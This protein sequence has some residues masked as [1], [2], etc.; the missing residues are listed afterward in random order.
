MNLKLRFLFGFLLQFLVLFLSYSLVFSGD[1]ILLIGDSITN[2]EV[3]STDGLGFRNDLYDLI[4]SS[5]YN[6]SF[7]GDVGQNPYKGHFRDGGRIEEF[8]PIGYGTGELDA[9]GVIDSLQPTI[10]MVFL[11]TNNVDGA[12]VS[13]FSVDNGLT[14]EDNASG[15]L[16]QFLNYLANW[17]NGNYGN[18]I[19]SILVVKIIPKLNHIENVDK[20]NAEISKFVNMAN[21]G[22]FHNIRP[23]L[24][25]II[26]CNSDFDINQMMSAGG[27][28]P[29]DLGYNFIAHKY[30]NVLRRLPS[31][32]EIASGNNQS[33]FSGTP[34]PDSIVVR[35]LDFAG[36]AASFTPIL[37]QTP[38]GQGLVE[39]DSI[40][41]TDQNGYARVKWTQLNTGV[42]NLNIEIYHFPDSK[43]VCNSYVNKQN[44]HPPVPPRWVFE[45]WA[46]QGDPEENNEYSLM[47]MVNKYLEN[48]IPLGAVIID[49]PWET[50]YNSFE[51]DQTYDQGSPDEPGYPD[52]KNMIDELHS[53]GIKVICWITNFI[54]INASDGDIA[55]RNTKSPNYDYAFNHGYFIN[56]GEVFNWWKGQGSAIDFFNPEA[57]DWYAGQLDK[58]LDLG[59]DGW[60]IDAGDVYVPDDFS[61]AAGTATRRMYSDEYYSFFYHYTIQKLGEENAVTIA[62]PYVKD[63]GPG[64]KPYIFAPISVSPV[65]WVG[66]Q[67]DNWGEKGLLEAL[68]NIFESVKLGY[69]VIGG[70]IGGYKRVQDENKELFV[71]WA[72]LGSL[73]PLMENGGLG[74]HEPWEYDRETIQ[75]YR[76]FANLHHSLVPYL[77]SSFLKLRE[78]GNTLLKIE[79]GT[80]EYRLGN[81][82]LIAPI[83]AAGGERT[84]VL[85]FGDD[86]INYWNDEEV[87]PGGMS[88]TQTYPLS[89]YPIFIRK[90]AIIPLKIDQSYTGIGDSSFADYLTLLIYPK[91]SSKIRV[92]DDS[93]DFVNVSYGE[94]PFISFLNVDPSDNNYIFRIKD[95]NCPQ[96]IVAKFDDTPV[97]L[98]SSPTFADFKKEKINTIYYASD[99]HYLWFKLFPVNQAV[100]L[101]IEKTLPETTIKKWSI[102]EVTLS[103]STNYNNPYLDVDVEG[104]FISENGDTLKIP[105]FWDGNDT[106]RVRMTPNE[107]GKW[108][109]TITSSDPQL[110]AAGTLS[111][112][113]STAHGFVHVSR[114]NSHAFAYSDG[115]PFFWLGDTDW[116]LYSLKTPF[117]GIFQ[118]YID[119]LSIQG[120]SIIQGLI[121][122]N[123]NTRTNG[124]G[125]NE[126]GLFFIDGNYNKIN[127]QFFKWIDK[128]IEYMNKK[129]IVPVIFF[130]WGHELP[131]FQKQQFQNYLKY[132]VSRYSAFNVI[133]CLSGEWDYSKYLKSDWEKYGNYLKRVDPYKHL[134][135]IHPKGGKGSPGTVG[136]DFGNQ[137]W[138]DFIMQQSYLF[139]NKIKFLLLKDW[140][141]NKPVVNA[142]SQYENHNYGNNTVVADNNIVRKDAWSINCFGGYYSYGGEGTVFFDENKWKESLNFLGRKEQEYLQKFFTGYTDFA[143]LTPYPDLVDTNNVLMSANLDSQYV[144]YFFRKYDVSNILSNLTGTYL[145]SWFNPINGTF[146]AT[147]YFDGNKSFTFNYPFKEDKDGVLLV[148]KY[149]NKKQLVKELFPSKVG[150]H[151]VS[152]HVLQSRGVPLI[153]V[154]SGTR[155]FSDTTQITLS[156]KSDIIIR[157]L[158]DDTDYYYN[159]LNS[160]DVTNSQIPY[161]FHTTLDTM[162]PKV[163]SLTVTPFADSCSIKIYAN[164]AAKIQFFYKRSDSTDFNQINFR[165]YTYLQTI[166]LS[167]LKIDQDYT[168]YF[169]L[170]DQKNH[171]FTSDIKYFKTL[172]RITLAGDVHFWSNNRPIPS[173]IFRLETGN[174]M[175]Q[176]TTDSTGKFFINITPDFNS[177]V[178]TPSRQNS[179]TPF[180]LS[181]DAALIARYVVGLQ[182]LSPDQLLAADVNCDGKIFSFD[183]ALIARYVVGL[184][185][186]GNSEVGNWAFSPDSLKL[187]S[188]K[189]DMTDLAFK[190]YIMG[191]IKGGAFGN[192]LPKIA[193]E[194]FNN[195]RLY[196]E[197]QALVF[198]INLESK[199]NILS[200]DLSVRLPKHYTFDGIEYS[201]YLNNFNINTNKINNSIRVSGFSTNY[202]SG[203]SNLKLKFMPDELHSNPV[204]S[205]DYLYINNQKFKIN[206]IHLNSSNQIRIYGNYP[207]PFNSTTIIKFET[208]QNRNLKIDIDNILGRNIK[209]LFNGKLEP[210]THEI[211]WNGT[212]GRG[213]SVS[214]GIYFVKIVSEG[215]TFFRKICLTK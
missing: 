151:E 12:I 13:P 74:K 88:I 128:R 57:A 7:F 205:V 208:W 3:G 107:A 166:S 119:S 20:F 123:P 81:D 84:V 121:G 145:Y 42:N 173:V 152:I 130:T 135:S 197:K 40:I 9:T 174:T 108:R 56:H 93:T 98:S 154:L 39:P 176:D 204:L 150:D 19:R 6:M 201:K 73:L 18:S 91:D 148:T 113:D 15:K 196:F 25:S 31:K 206:Y 112:L 27:I 86:W 51:F 126:G 179:S 106:W 122:E 156:N 125:I 111:V 120:F 199:I 58:V 131:K 169:R 178:L 44:T 167:G 200:F 90:G 16:A 141:Y 60:K 94:H 100:H 129:S 1:R 5:G 87:L 116:D 45:P 68:T 133:W 177:T 77:Y 76:Y 35:A 115:T 191:D 80:W 63:E 75:I 164:E 104:T 207:N 203:D 82:L 158:Q 192:N 212:D 190:G 175:V 46:W 137:S 162:P 109:Y 47:N 64:G 102:F 43:I 61:T 136:D 97:I 161:Y 172:N 66:D 52:A 24:I 186:I 189:S 69:S 95:R 22:L 33:V 202:L 140:K 170:F 17:A 132:S 54:N 153:L 83:Y 157:N 103:T 180:I 134:L 127:P 4:Q 194:R 41:Y 48:N 29:N 101:T 183:A 155:N 110:T 163:D 185:P 50:F 213:L 209:T 78:N 26:D 124:A 181:Y 214:S 149:D 114:K 144:F 37:F 62:R 143:S 49:S 193:T 71:R 34:L 59:I 142:N 139:H 30:F 36:N 182:D 23:S 65:S 79:N 21:M 138:L 146:Y 38:R 2:G 14:F 8:Y 188:L 215:K 147:N 171:V 67:E 187:D 28:H 105:G 53:K 168:F 118:A 70:D 160:I 89:Q 92:Y 211:K 165:D 184:P 195:Y 55:G 117:N 11:G 72:E 99:D 32:L 96:K 159:I 10:A 198:Q 85:P 210:G